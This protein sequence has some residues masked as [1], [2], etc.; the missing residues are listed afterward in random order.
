MKSVLLP[1]T[2]PENDEWVT[3]RAIDVVVDLNAHLSTLMIDPVVLTVPVYPHYPSM[4][5]YPLLLQQLRDE[6]SARQAKLK[7]LLQG[8]AGTKGVA[9][10]PELPTPS[11]QLSQTDGDAWAAVQA[12][13]PVHDV[14]LFVRR[15]EPGEPFETSELLKDTLEYSGRPILVLTDGYTPKLN[16]R[17]GIAWNGSAES[18]RAVSAALPILSSAEEVVIFSFV[19]AKTDASEAGR[20]SS[21]LARHGIKSVVKSRSTEGSVGDALLSAAETSGVTLLVTGGYTHSRLRQAVLGGVTRHLLARS[22][23]PMLMAH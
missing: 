4:T 1:L 21:F 14:V 13:A 19:T 18:A 11:A 17:V 7:S 8:A 10:G 3:D 12:E 20:L 2:H 9:F 5:H 22:A 16:T 23:I 6:S 15:A